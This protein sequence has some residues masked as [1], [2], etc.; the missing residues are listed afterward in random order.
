M[1]RKY[2]YNNDKGHGSQTRASEGLTRANRAFI[3][4]SAPQDFVSSH[5]IGNFR[6]IFN[7]IEYGDEGYV[8]P[9]R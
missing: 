5:S 8:T 9:R 1:S 6:W 4:S 2:E 3:P 7:S